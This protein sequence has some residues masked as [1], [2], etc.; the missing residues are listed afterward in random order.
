MLHPLRNSSP[1]IL[2]LEITYT[3]FLSAVIY[4]LM[5]NYGTPLKN[6]FYLILPKQKKTE[7]QHIHVTWFYKI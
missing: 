4:Y 1:W 3:L 2:D 7:Q 6:T 5:T